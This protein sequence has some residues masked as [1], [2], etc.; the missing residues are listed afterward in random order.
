[1]SLFL[2]ASSEKNGSWPVVLVLLMHQFRAPEQNREFWW[3]LL[4]LR[5][6]V[7]IN[8]RHA[9][10]WVIIPRNRVRSAFGQSIAWWFVGCGFT[11]CQTVSVC[12]S[13]SSGCTRF[14]LLPLLSSATSQCVP[15]RNVVRPSHC[16]K[17]ARK[18][19]GCQ[20]VRHGVQGREKQVWRGHVGI[21]VLQCSTNTNATSMGKQK[22]GKT[23]RSLGLSTHSFST[24]TARDP[25][26]HFIY[27]SGDAL[28][29]FQ[30]R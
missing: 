8:R 26:I 9:Y 17:H 14:W 19:T 3:S 1:M 16:I 4:Q 5:R 23:K 30:V 13:R 2:R 7:Y 29:V 11:Q 24:S 27:Q 25:T 12:Y 22:S 21:G 6:R 10:G 28:L 15:P 20:R 18:R